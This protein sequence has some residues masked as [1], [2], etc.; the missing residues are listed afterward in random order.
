MGKEIRRPPF[1]IDGK[2]AEH[3]DVKLYQKI[4]IKA[5]DGLYSHGL[6]DDEI[7]V[8]LNDPEPKTSMFSRP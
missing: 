7:K 3:P 1:R 5:L 6:N 8:F 4:E 2:F